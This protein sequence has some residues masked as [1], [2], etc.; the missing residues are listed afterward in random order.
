MEISDEWEAGKAY[1][2][3]DGY[4]NELKS[5]KWHPKE[6]TNYFTATH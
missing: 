4:S 6:A 3:F 1:L 5:T 2:T